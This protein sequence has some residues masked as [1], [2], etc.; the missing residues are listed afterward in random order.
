[1]YVVQ[2]IQNERSFGNRA[3]SALGIAIIADA[4]DFDSIVTGMLYSVTNFMTP[5]SVI[6]HK[7]Y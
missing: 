5:V 6:G 3:I 1:M 7:E 2:V 4:L